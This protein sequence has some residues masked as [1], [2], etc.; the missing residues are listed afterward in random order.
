MY[1]GFA[2]SADFLWPSDR[3]QCLQDQSGARHPT[4]YAAGCLAVLVTL[5]CSAFGRP[6]CLICGRQCG[7]LCSIA[8]GG[9]SSR[10]LWRRSRNSKMVISSEKA[11][12]NSDPTTASPAVVTVVSPVSCV[13]VCP[14]LAMPSWKADHEHGQAYEAGE[15][16][17]LLAS[18]RRDNSGNHRE[19]R[20][21]NQVPEPCVV[22]ERQESMVPRR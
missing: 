7:G 11:K 17:V 22:Q 5:C 20:T 15:S 18:G 16:E 19:H 13:P 10:A 8:S 14:A 2:M 9:T 3:S 21:S 1:A 4:G 12:L 6:H